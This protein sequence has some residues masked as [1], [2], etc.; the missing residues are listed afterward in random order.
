MYRQYINMFFFR[1]TLHYTIDRHPVNWYALFTS[2]IFPK[3]KLS[4]FCTMT[5]H[6][7]SACNGQSLY[8]QQHQMAQ[9]L[10][11]IVQKMPDIFGA[12]K[13]Q[14]STIT[15]SEEKVFGTFFSGCVISDFSLV[16]P[17]VEDNFPVN[18]NKFM[19]VDVEEI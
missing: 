6:R 5:S 15:F 2:V 1:A 13:Q 19:G 12:N 3:R 7:I 17:I 4:N 11:N 18:Q 8:C 10:S 14:D 9:N 16:S